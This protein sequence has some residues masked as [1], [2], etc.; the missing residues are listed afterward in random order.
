QATFA[1]EG[2]SEG[3]FGGHSL[4]TGVNEGF[5]AGASIGPLGHESPG[6][7]GNLLGMDVA[8]HGQCL[9]RRRIVSWR[10]GF[11]RQRGMKALLQAFHWGRE[12]VASAHNTHSITC[13]GILFEGCGQILSALSTLPTTLIIVQ[14]RRS[15]AHHQRPATR[16]PPHPEA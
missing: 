1:P 13:V 5:D 11:T 2:L 9:R 3:G 14:T 16:S 4:G 15:S 6:T 10:E 12:S 7:H 8:D